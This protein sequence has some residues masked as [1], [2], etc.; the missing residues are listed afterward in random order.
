[1]TA[2]SLPRNP[3]TC[4]PALLPGRNDLLHSADQVQGNDREGAENSLESCCPIQGS[5][6]G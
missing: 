3:S 6:A 2:T 5:V 4:Y 1:M